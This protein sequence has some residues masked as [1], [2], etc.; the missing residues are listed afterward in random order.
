MT[1][2]EKA[3]QSRKGLID[4]IKGRAKEVVGALTRNDS[5]TAQGQLDQAEAKKRRE[6]GRLESVADA[7]PPKRRLKPTRRKWKVRRSEAR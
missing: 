6:A 2:H 3:D 4:A 7:E 5:L 1:E